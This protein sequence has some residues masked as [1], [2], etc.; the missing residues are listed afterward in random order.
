[1]ILVG[2][3]ESGAI[4]RELR[5]RGHDA[6]SVDL[7][8]SA[9]NSSYHIQ[10]DIF[11]ALKNKAWKRGIIHP[12]CRYLTHA[13]IKHLFS[14]HGQMPLVPCEKRWREMLDAA[15]FFRKLLEL[16]FPVVLENPRMHP[17]G[18]NAVRVWPFCTTQPHHHGDKAF[19]ET[20]FWRNDDSFKPLTET[21]RL[22]VPK[23]GTPEYKAWSETFRMPPGPDREKL[24]SRT[25]LGIA[26]A[27]A[28][29]WF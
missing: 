5:A 2:M 3:E 12:V 22:L 27:I 7:Q 19:K 10:E 15:A 29:Q 6:W 25:Y 18:L 16:P 28:Q 1:M 11:V 20:M 9:D 26:N 13:G 21:N 14:N 23:Y 24:R 8:P 4:R 17:Y